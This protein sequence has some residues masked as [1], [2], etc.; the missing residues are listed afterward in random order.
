[1]HFNIFQLNNIFFDPF[2]STCKFQEKNKKILINLISR[3][4][5]RKNS[6]SFGSINGCTEIVKVLTFLKDNP[7][8]PNNDGITPIHLAAF[9]GHTQIVKLGVFFLFL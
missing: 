5:L 3:K 8:A 4:K 7:S 1:M 9:S 6:N 2:R